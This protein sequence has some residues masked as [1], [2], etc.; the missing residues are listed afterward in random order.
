MT[1]AHRPQLEAARGRSDQVAGSLVHV[2]MLPAHTKLKFRQ[3]GQGGV[4]DSDLTTRDFKA[5]LLAAETEH[6]TKIGKVSETK[7]VSDDDDV[8]LIKDEEESIEAKRR[9]IL[10]E[11][12]SI[13]AD[14]DDGG[15]E[16]DE[17]DSSNDSSEDEDDEDETALLMKELE[18]IKHERALEKQRQ[19]EE[20]ASK[21][22]EEREKE[23]AYGNRLLN[24]PQEGEFNVKRD[25]TEDTVFKKQAK[26]FTNSK[27]KGFVNDLLRSDFHRKF[28]DKYV[29]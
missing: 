19:E 7:R 9:R 15:S 13:D 24:P 6:L 28:I 21:R 27:Q 29:K 5:E 25:W 20:E 8:L 2:R 18:K 11:H 10:E 16:S 14:D 4:A 26:T 23:I 1:T 22:Q 3:V 12:K 17:E